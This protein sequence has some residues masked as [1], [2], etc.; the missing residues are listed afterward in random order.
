MSSSL[1]SVSVGS[2]RRFHRDRPSYARPQ[3]VDRASP[4]RLRFENSQTEDF[5]LDAPTFCDFEFVPGHTIL[6]VD[7]DEFGRNT[8]S[9][10]LTVSGFQVTQAAN[11]KEAMACLQGPLCPELIILDLLMP[12]FDGYEFVKKQSCHADFAH[13][14]VIVVSATDRVQ[15]RQGLATIVAHFEKPIPV[16]ELLQKIREQFFI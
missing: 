12:E 8:L 13:I 9:Q 1:S 10:I 6:L 2:H 7:D 11:G 15:V 14:P 4:R 16:C 3:R 5:S